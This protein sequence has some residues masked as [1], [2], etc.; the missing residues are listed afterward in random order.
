MFVLLCTTARGFSESGQNIVFD[1]PG[2]GTVANYGTFPGYIDDL[3]RAVGYFV[4]AQN[5][6]HGFVRYP[7]GRIATIDAPGAGATPGTGQGTIAYCINIQG[8][9]V[10]LYQDA[11]NLVHGFL[12]EPNGHFVTFDAPGAGSGSG[13]GTLGFNINLEGTILGETVDNNNAIHAFLRSPG[14]VFTVFDAPNAGTGSGQGTYTATGSGLNLLGVATGDYLDANGTPHGYVRQRGGALISFDV[15]GSAGTFP[16]SIN[17]EGATTGTFGKANAGHGFIRSA[18][19]ACITFDVPGAFNNT[20]PKGITP[21][22]VTTGF[23]D[24]SNVV[25]HGFIRYP[26]GAFT[27]F[28]VPGAGN[29]PGSQQGTLPFGINF[30]GEIVGQVRD[31]NNVYHG[32]IRIP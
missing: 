4:D 30:W 16:E 27:K 11:N 29:V 23:W 8:T 20:N 15:P 9:I 10:G 22:G 26:N 31:S 7:D 28:D 32:F 12:R 5:L 19:G 25:Y 24:D 17:P 1:A 18:N 6:Y 2:A 14:G 21:F 3:G 13:Q